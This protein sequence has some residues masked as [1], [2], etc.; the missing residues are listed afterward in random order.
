MANR[1]SMGRNYKVYNWPD[2]R[3]RYPTRLPVANTDR[4]RLVSVF[5]R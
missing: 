1:L 3:T 4:T 2:E 5:G